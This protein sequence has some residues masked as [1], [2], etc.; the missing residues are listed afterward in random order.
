MSRALRSSPDRATGP[1]GVP[2][3]EPAAAPSGAAKPLKLLAVSKSFPGV[4]ALREVDFE[5]RP[6]EVH[7]LVGENGAG[8]ST[9]LKLLSG[10][11]QPDSGSIELNGTHVFLRD[12][13][14]SADL[15][16]ATIYQEL[17]LVPWLSVAHNLFLGRERL[18]GRLIT[19][20]RRLAGLAT[21][22][23]QKLG[24]TVD[25]MAL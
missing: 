15:G 6:G 18:A 11:L 22:E 19:S 4:R 9:L 20:K 24:L 16:I 25:P 1:P 14:A 2:P 12:P 3:R 5:L 10:A 7:A 21:N 17:S 13:R 23:L 8:K